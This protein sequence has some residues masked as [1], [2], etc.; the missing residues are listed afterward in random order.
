MNAVARRILT[1]LC[2]R[3]TLNGV[4]LPD[5][6][7]LPAYEGHSLANVPATALAHF[8]VPGPPTPPLAPEVVGD[9]LKGARKLVVLLI[10]AL[11]YLPLTAQMASDR[12]LSLNALARRGRYV[13]LTSVFPST[14]SAT[15]STLHTG[16]PPSGHGIMGYRMY[17]PERGVVANMIRLSP[18]ADER[19]NQLLHAPE[20]G[21]ALLGVPTVH[22]RLTRAGV[23]SICLIEKT[24]FRSGLSQM[25]YADA[26]ATI[27]YVNSS[28]LFVQ[29]RKLITTDPDTPA[30]IWAYWGALD[31]IQHDYGTWGEEPAA[32]VRSLAYSLQTE[33][34]APLRRSRACAAALMLTAD[35]GHI[36][37]AEEDILPATR[38]RR[39][40]DALTAPPT[41]TGRSPY[42]HL[43]DGMAGALKDYLNRRLGD[44][45]LALRSG[46]A[47]AEG[48]WGPGE[49]RAE[50]PGRVGDLVLLMRGSRMLFYPYRKGV[51]PF[52]LAGGSHGGLH[53]EEMLIP[54]LCVRL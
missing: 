46:E 35:H 14:T 5:R 36:H 30:C 38:F 4:A 48:L 42:L 39:L 29:I 41:G 45:V 24:I 3:R 6:F 22:R 13:P 18:D 11:G 23:K 31:T 54:F 37:V 33:L 21:P 19:P 28:D 2:A 34:V 12:G 9:Q 17:L 7:L 27:P 44:R 52:H 50:A 8:G 43:K 20:D 47:L 10:D 1:R 25:L 40:R 49:V 15:L 51:R 26:T 32:E 53:E 16:L